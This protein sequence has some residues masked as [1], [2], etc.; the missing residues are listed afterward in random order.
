[1]PPVI[2]VINPN[3]STDVTAGID[4]AM[5]PLRV[6][7][8]PSIEC[9]TLAEGPPGIQTQRDVDGVVVPL[10]ALARS[11]EARAAAFVI[12]CFSDP[13]LHALR[14]AT[15]KPVFGI[16]ESAALTAM[17]LGQTFGVIAILG[18]SIPRHLRGWGAMGIRDRLAGEVAIGVEVTDLARGGTLDRMIAAGM[19]LRDEHGAQ[20]L[21]MGCAGMAGFRDALQTAV[22][23]PVVEPS[24]AAAAMAI[25]R[26]LL[27]WQAA[28]R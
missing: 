20:V 10:L 8:G 27:G 15:A 14:E 13:G 18:T 12:A 3:S 7:G 16:S 1:M 2:Y 28:G 6:V 24:Q 19:R 5:A 22:G 21:V 17:T 25:G 23:L 11:L 9:L 4:A 26:V